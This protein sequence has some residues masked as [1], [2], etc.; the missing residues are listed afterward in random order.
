MKKTAQAIFNRV[1]PYYDL[2][3]YLPEMI[4][5][6]KWRQI[7]WQHVEGERILELGIGTGKNIPYFPDVSE[8]HGCDISWNMISMAKKK[9]GISLSKAYI[10]VMNVEELG[11]QD[12]TFD[13]VVGT[14]IICSVDR[15]METFEE[16]QRICKPGGKILFLENMR[17]KNKIVGILMDVV[18]FF[19]SR[20][21][22]ANITRPTLDNIKKS[23]L[24]ITE[25]IPLLYDISKII[26]CK[27]PEK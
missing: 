25:V 2:I 21:K 7:I 14:F 13:T 9:E 19:T 26:V 12:N 17:S 8:I 6:S 18:N 15:P 16:I 11:Y 24:Q 20:I 4:A 23:N 27:N 5:F 1:A 10:T 22:G 3:E